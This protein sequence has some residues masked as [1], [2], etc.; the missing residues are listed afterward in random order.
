MQ[1]RVFEIYDSANK[2]IPA[3]C[4]LLK[5][6]GVVALPTETV[7]GLA[8]NAQN[9]DAVHKIFDAKGRPADNPLIVHIAQK[10]ELLPLVKE[11]PTAAQ[12]CIDAFWPGPFTVILPKTDAVPSITSG[13]LD[14][15][16]V[17]MPSNP[18]IN[19]VIKGCGFPLAAPSA[20]VSGKPSPTSARHVIEDM[21]GKIAGIVKSYDCAVGVEST[22]VS[23][24]NDEVRLLRPG[25][26]TLEML[27]KIVPDIIVDEG[28]LHTVKKALSPGMKYKHYAPDCHVT[29]IEGTSGAFCDYVKKS[30][31]FALCLKEDEKHLNKKCI[32][33]GEK[34]E[35]ALFT[36]L[37]QLDE[38]GIK[39]A[40]CHATDKHG[41]GLAV[42]NRMLRACGFDIIK[43]PFVIGVTGPSGAGKTSLSLAAQKCGIKTVDCDLFAKDIVEGLKK[44]L[45]EAFGDDLYK[46][47]NL[48]RKLLADRAF[49]NGE[50]TEKLNK[51]TLPHIVSA[52]KNEIQTTNEGFIL[53]DGATLIESGAVGLCNRIVAVISPK[54][55]RL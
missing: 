2:D 4:D 53:L 45:C 30:G 14:T 46:N 10:E 16:A 23:F 20:N 50:N 31:A 7:Y 11:V 52:L 1:T 51:I 48:D 39:K 40:V 34:P 55:K 29:L 3:V 15:V 42:Y 43:L 35:T 25:G 24:L 36:A 22:V 47:G 28:V 54:D 27:Q 49:K 33:L 41:T 12:K 8:A 18:V 6:G 21:D 9:E 13:G 19:A 37:R 44:P 26:I 17:R 38:L 5:Q 32:S